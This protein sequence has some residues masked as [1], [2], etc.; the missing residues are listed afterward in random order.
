MIIKPLLAFLLLTAR[1]LKCAVTIFPKFEE[2]KEIIPVNFG[3]SKGP[4]EQFCALTACQRR[5]RAYSDVDLQEREACENKTKYEDVRYESFYEFLRLKIIESDVTFIE[6]LEKS[7]IRNQLNFPLFKLWLMMDKLMIEPSISNENRNNAAL[8]EYLF[9]VLKLTRKEEEGP[10]DP[11]LFNLGLNS[12]KHAIRSNKPPIILKTLMKFLKPKMTGKENLKIF[13]IIETSMPSTG[14]LLKD[15]KAF[16]VALEE[17][18]PIDWFD[19]MYNEGLDDNEFPYHVLLSPFYFLLSKHSKNPEIIVKVKEILDNCAFDQNREN[20]E[21]LSKFIELSD[22]CSGGEENLSIKTEIFEF[23]LMKFEIE[24]DGYENQF[25]LAVERSCLHLVEAFLIYTEV[26]QDDSD[27]ICTSVLNS[28]YFST[29]N[30]MAILIITYRSIFADEL[31]AMWKSLNFYDKL[32]LN[33]IRVGTIIELLKLSNDFDSDYADFE[34]FSKDGLIIHPFPEPEEYEIIANRRGSAVSSSVLNNSWIVRII[35]A[36]YY[37]ISFCSTSI[38]YEY[39][40]SPIW[41]EVAGTINSL[42]L[43]KNSKH[44]VYFDEGLRTRNG[45]NIKFINY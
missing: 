37:G 11:N 18:D 44:R 43:I 1:I 26:I 27:I 20:M 7:I 29:T 25:N 4:V 34:E 21:I 33:C 42:L 23:I 31:T 35:L 14:N 9:L 13:K 41:R 12:L 40:S 6:T 30:E 32:K 28:L 10:Y 45:A 3:I 8:I 5:F 36:K 2:E 15:F 16:S 24:V 38:R 22:F 17:L 39:D 19:Y